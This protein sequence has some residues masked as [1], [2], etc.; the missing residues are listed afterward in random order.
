[1]KTKQF[2]SIIL[3]V[4]LPKTATT[5]IQNY[6]HHHVIYLQSHGIYYPTMW[7][8]NHAIPIAYISQSHAHIDRIS[9]KHQHQDQVDRVQDSIE[10]FQ[11][12]IQSTDAETL[13]LSSEIISSFDESSL[14]NLYRYLR[15][16]TTTISVI[17]YVRHPVALAESLIPTM[18][19]GSRISRSQIDQQLRI[20]MCN[21]TKSK[22]QRL[23]HV[24]GRDALSIFAYENGRLH[25]HSSIGHFLNSINLNPFDANTQLY[26]Q[27]TR[28]SQFSCD[29]LDIYN[30]HTIQ[31][32]T[33]LT[34]DNV[35]KLLELAGSPFSLS[36]QQRQEIFEISKSDREWIH[37]TLNIDYRELPAPTT[38]SNKQNTTDTSLKDS[39][40]SVFNDLSPALQR[41]I[42]EHLQTNE[43]NLFN[44]HQMLFFNQSY[45]AKHHF[46]AN[47]PHRQ[48][49]R[50]D[51]MYLTC[52]AVLAA[53]NNYEAAVMLLQHAL[54]LNH[55]S[56]HI[57][58]KLHEYS[59]HISSK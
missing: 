2:K 6:C 8:S 39:I 52:A 4:G 54:Q 24:F 41:A 47:V 30:R 33:N 51:T 35:F 13:L 55:Y 53:H 42:L 15:T 1:M 16:F 56:V 34:Q 7:P 32:P 20:F 58:Q 26:T 44:E 10:A 14:I 29:V 57:Q 28:P 45:E 36:A 37:T 46:V 23:Q 59:A 3:H 43:S 18:L 27:N 49:I 5:S 21:Y 50:S 22:V 12:D 40:V 19:M 17:M 48:M 9:K 31:S 11:N 25:P 38:H